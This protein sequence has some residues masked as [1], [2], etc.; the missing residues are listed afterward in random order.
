MGFLETYINMQAKNSSHLLQ[1]IE[2]D[3]CMNPEMK[4]SQA[5]LLFLFDNH[6][7]PIAQVR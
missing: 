3:V 7:L 6:G 5:E 4:N 1:D 2:K